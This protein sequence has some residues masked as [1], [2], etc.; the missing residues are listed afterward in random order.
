MRGERW[1]LRLGEYLVGRA[2][3]QLP[4]K[5]RDERYREW[6]AELPVILHDRQIRLAPRRAV[7]MVAYAA[8]TFRGAALTHVRERRRR[9][10]LPLIPSLVTGVVNSTWSIWNIA[11][12][13]G[14]ALNYLQLGWGL[15]LAAY[16]IG[17]IVR[18]AERVG[19]LILISGILAGV[20]VN[21]W[22]AA[23]YP[24]NW[25]QYYAAAALVF[26]LLAWWPVNRWV[27][28]RRRSPA[29]K[30]A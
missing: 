6:A 7:R 23:T 24:G 20:A 28:A 14:Q 25:S 21:L 5:I 19:T 15:L 1:L 9:L 2:C 12:A 16:P 29:H 22:A 13:P 30:Q 4:R 27:R 17:F 18:C 8:D 11:L 26:V 10:P 3:R